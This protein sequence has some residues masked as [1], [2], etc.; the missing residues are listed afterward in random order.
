MASRP[1]FFE[2]GAGLCSCGGGEGGKGGGGKLVSLLLVAIVDRSLLSFVVRLE[3][4][5]V[6]DKLTS[7]AKF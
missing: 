3:T 7:S 4:L 1:C 2:T 6:R 5:K